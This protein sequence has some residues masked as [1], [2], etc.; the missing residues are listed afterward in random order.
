M[1][2]RKLAITACAVLVGG[3]LAGG[4]LAAAP[5]RA[6]SLP[7]TV[8]LLGVDNAATPTLYHNIH[9][10]D[11]SFQGW[12]TVE[13]NCGSQYFDV[14]T[15]VTG[16]SIAALPD[17]ST[18]SVALGIDGNLYFNIR[19]ANGS[20]QG[21]AAI[22]GN[23]GSKYFNGDD[24]SITG[25][26]N[27]SAQLIATGD[28]GNLY[29]NIRN[30]NGSW[31]GWSAIPG[32]AGAQYFSDSWASIAGMPDGSSQ[33]IATDGTNE[34]YH[35]IRSANGTWQ[36]WQLVEGLPG[37]LSQPFSGFTPSITGMPD[38]SSQIVEEEYGGDLYHNIRNANGIWQGWRPLGGPDG[39]SYYIGSA[40]IAS[41]PNG[42]SQVFTTTVNSNA[43]WENTRASNGSWSGWTLL[44]G[45]E[46]AVAAA[47]WGAVG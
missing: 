24:P 45:Y 34:T 12:N 7:D 16:A 3:A 21:W 10:A 25:M 27:G 44:N 15:A 18:Q 11:N 43:T 14:G 47:G 33:L 9:N 42:S 4:A 23:G 28:D 26:P 30:A 39:S 17:G 46:M 31:R 8:Q 1:I 5:A 6:S 20:W 29:F 22:E 35:N 32:I 36:G 19:Y 2:R 38:G 41:L 13:G 37:S 40:V